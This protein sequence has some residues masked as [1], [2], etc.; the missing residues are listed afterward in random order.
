MT[1]KDFLQTLYEDT[2][3]H[4]VI[5]SMS[6]QTEKKT[7]E[8]FLLNGTDGPL[9]AAA[10]YIAEIK[11]QSDVYFGIGTQAKQPKGNQRGAAPGV[12]SLPGLWLD[13]DIKGPGHAAE[14]LPETM[15]DVSKIL[16]AMPLDPTVTVNTGGG[17]HCYWLFR[18]PWTLDTEEER[19]KAA[20]LSNQ[21]QQLFIERAA[22][23]NWTVDNTATLAQ[24]L[25]P[26]GTF[27]HKPIRKGFGNKPAKVT[28]GELDPARRYNPDDIDQFIP[29]APKPKTTT[30]TKT[31]DLPLADLAPILEGC[32]WM[33]HCRDD[34]ETLPNADWYYMLSVIGHCVDGRRH[35]H[36]L[37]A[38]YPRYKPSETD[39]SFARATEYGP[40]LCRTVRSKFGTYCKDCPHDLGSPI[41][42]G[43]SATEEFDVIE[44]STELLETFLAEADKKQ[45]SAMFDQEIIGALAK[46]PED[47]LAQRKMQLLELYGRSFPKRDFDKAIKAAKQ[48][49]LRVVQPGERAEPAKIELDGLVTEYDLLQPFGWRVNMRGILKEVEDKEGELLLIRVATAPVVITG[50]LEDINTGQHFYRMK[51][52][53]NGR[54]HEHVIERK[55]AAN[56]REV[57]S[58]AGVGAPVTSGTAKDLVSYLADFEHTNKERVTQEQITEQ[59]GW[60]KGK[61]FFLCGQDAIGSKTPVHFSG[62]IGSVET[63]RAF[64]PEG[65]LDQ[66]KDLVSLAYPFLRVSAAVC[67]SFAAPLLQIVDCPNFILDFAYRTSSGKSTALRL[68]ASVW[69]RGDER[70]H[71]SLISKWNSTQVGIE[72][73]AGLLNG[74]PLL[75]D[76]SASVKKPG[77]IENIVYMVAGGMGRTR[78]AKQGGLDH[79]QRFYTVAIS[80]GEEQL[81]RYTKQGGAAARVISLW[82]SP[83]DRTDTDRTLPIVTKINS[84]CL[85]TYGVAGRAFVEY[86]LERRD[87]WDELKKAWRECS[88]K[89]LEVHGQGSSVAARLADYFALLMIAGNVANDA[90]GLDLP[91]LLPLWEEIVEGSKEADK[92]LVALEQTFGWAMSHNGEFYGQGIEDHNGNQRPSGSNGWAGTWK[93][94]EFGTDLCFFQDRL[95][96]VLEDYGHT[97]E[98]ILNQWAERGWLKVDSGKKTVK[99]VRCHTGE[100]MY[101]VVFSDE[102][103]E[104]VFGSDHNDHSS[105]VF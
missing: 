38:P 16:E 60:Q 61:E 52:H 42:L 47:Q 92:A 64:E 67:A 96:D 104:L 5:W 31:Q 13:I 15:E 46:L 71:E 93:A 3:G 97:A 74:L 26:V 44:E 84:G 11:T 86:L 57:V 14:N 33:A 95:R 76:D 68:A 62:G 36:E 82:G 54:W 98:A 34:A 9:T 73:R 27:N 39:K 94:P 29:V 2:D 48:K 8:S 45:P 66:W 22:E 32:A 78:G 79:T 41:Q 53:R 12:H 81:T 20:D 49:H 50:I 77:D 51:W 23:L 55:T 1:I 103:M 40:V 4:L 72:R 58:L 24:V 105:D 100:R 101:M 70:L 25:R 7:T 37:S 83:F 87:R 90:L 18:E 19:Q 6:A 89:L 28:L 59:L 30:K 91:N 88:I 43:R 17:V 102:A 99:R 85:D 10:E 69:G 56:S 35:A 75:L 80:T 21:F 65:T 63:S